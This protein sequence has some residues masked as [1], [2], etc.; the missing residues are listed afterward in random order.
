M[1]PCLKYSGYLGHRY[2]VIEPSD[3]WSAVEGWATVAQ[4]GTL[5]AALGMCRGYPGRE[6][7]ERPQMPQRC[8]RWGRVH[9]PLEP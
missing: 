8:R 4:C 2:V 6:I 1:R 7:W 3:H 5:K 9:P